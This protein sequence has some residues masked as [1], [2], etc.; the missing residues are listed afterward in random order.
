MAYGFNDKKEKVEVY[1]TSETYNKSEVYN[2]TEVYS[3]SETYSK[4]EVYSKEETYNKDEVY[5]KPN[6]LVLYGTAANVEHY[7][8]TTV[9]LDGRAFGY[10]DLDFS[11]YVVVGLMQLYNN[12]D[13]WTMPMYDANTNLTRP[14]A[15]II[16]S[17]NRLRVFLYNG[18]SVTQS[19][20]YKVALMKV[21]DID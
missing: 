11:D 1:P 18:S 7:T 2:K 10:A 15:N 17:T 19:V 9:E 8:S 20:H 3:K 4:T 14:L 6:F 5:P 13:I 16:E 12:S 21:R